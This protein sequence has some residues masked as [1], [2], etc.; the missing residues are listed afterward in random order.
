MDGLKRPRLRYGFAC[1]PGRPSAHLLLVLTCFVAVL[2][3]P[4]S[5]EFEKFWVLVAKRSQLMHRV[6]FLRIK[7]TENQPISSTK[8]TLTPF[9]WTIF[10]RNFRSPLTIWFGARFVGLAQQVPLHFGRP[11][12]KFHLRLAET[13]PANVYNVYTGFCGADLA[14]VLCD[15]CQPTS[16]DVGVSERAETTFLA[17]GFSEPAGSFCDSWAGTTTCNH[18]WAKT[19]ALKKLE[20]LIFWGFSFS[21]MDFGSYP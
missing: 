19:F 17:F 16:H 2:A 9:Q 13:E 7:G 8:F 15:S 1:R 18:A 10:H 14:A 5:F 6:S 21:S 12:E 3:G 11:W 20:D 4:C